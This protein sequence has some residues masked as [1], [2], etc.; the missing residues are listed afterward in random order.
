VGI[1]GFGRGQRRPGT[2]QGGMIMR[3]FL[4]HYCHPSV[5]VKSFVGMRFIIVI[6]QFQITLETY[7]QVL[8]HCMNM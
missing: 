8:T 7:C 5:Y 4:Y 6:T 1:R 2:G 3:T